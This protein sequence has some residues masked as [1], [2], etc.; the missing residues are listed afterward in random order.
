[1]TEKMI[2][3]KIEPAL[4]EQFKQ[5]CRAAGIQQSAL[6]RACVARFLSPERE[7]FLEELGFK[8]RTYWTK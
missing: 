6:L 3:F 5:E 7:G 8:R 1:M 4:A 2:A